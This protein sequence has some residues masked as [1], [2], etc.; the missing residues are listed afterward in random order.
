MLYYRDEEDNYEKL[1]TRRINV[2]EALY[3]RDQ[4]KRKRRVF[5]P[6]CKSQ[7]V[8][9]FKNDKE[10]LKTECPFCDDSDITLLP[11]RYIHDVTSDET[12]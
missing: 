2:F 5:C 10:I 4:I 9:Y 8:W 12:T 11:I 6:G 1:H 7:L 3:Y